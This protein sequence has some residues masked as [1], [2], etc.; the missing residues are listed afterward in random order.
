M[1]QKPGSQ[2]SEFNIAKLLVLLGV[3]IDCA[4]VG[5]STLQESGLQFPWISF[6]MIVVGMLTKVLPA[7]GYV[8]SRTM[9]KLAAQQSQAAEVIK[10]AVPL[11][12][13]VKE[14]LKP[15][16]DPQGT[17]PSGPPAQG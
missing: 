9:V 3:V 5:L 8:R 12:Q 4:A 13:G 14:A 10:A 16:K 6:A 2:T 1:E 15:E 11:V 17:P 7:L